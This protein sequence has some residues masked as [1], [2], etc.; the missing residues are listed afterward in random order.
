[1]PEP[2]EVQVLGPNDPTHT[3]DD[4]E[5]EEYDYDW[6]S[7]RMCSFPCEFCGEDESE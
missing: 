2:E 6:E 7:N 4:V 5:E 3:D 1:M